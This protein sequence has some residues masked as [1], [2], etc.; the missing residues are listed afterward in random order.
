MK[1]SITFSFFILLSFSSHAQE[2]HS[3]HGSVPM[4]ADSTSHQMPMSPGDCKEMMKWDYSTAS[5]QPVPMAGMPMKMWMIHGN[6]FFVQNFEEK[7]RGDNK[8]AVPN[9]I[10]GDVGKSVGNYAHYIN[11]NLML[12]FEKWTFPEDG[13]PELLQIGEKNENDEPYIDAQHPHS[14]PI[15]GLTLSDTISLDSDKYLKIFFAPRGQATDGPIAFMHRPSGMSNPSAPLGHHVGQDLSHITSTVLGTAL[16]LDKHRIEL[17]TFNGTEP[18]P[19]K[20]DLPIGELNSYATRLIHK[21][22]DNTF[23]M[24]SAA[25]VKSPE[26]DDSTLDH[27]WRYSASLYNHFAL[28]NGW[29][30]SNSLIYGQVNGYEHISSLKSFLEEFWIHSEKPYSF[31]G[32]LEVLERTSGQLEIPSSGDSLDPHWIT[33]ITLGH[34]YDL[35][36]YAYGKLSAGISVTKNFLPTEFK[37]AYGGDP[38]GGRVF[39]QIQGMKMGD[40]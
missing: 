10:M 4:S 15:M 8:F 29:M 22:S 3:E 26:K 24:A 20:V 23:A 27:L 13:Y 2:S 14:S 30:I 38:W 1:Y 17:S 39:L 37:D 36:K 16:D 31:W 5:C 25:Y 6:A 34:T 28:Q 33:A 32:R 12:T 7:P 40:Y 19:S 35:K 11:L 21:F 18:E 9:M